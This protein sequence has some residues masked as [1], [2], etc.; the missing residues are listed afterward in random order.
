MGKLKPKKDWKAKFRRR[1]SLEQPPNDV[2][3]YKAEF[4]R[5]VERTLEL[6][7]PNPDPTYSSKRYWTPQVLQDTLTRI[8]HQF[9]IADASVLESNCIRVNYELIDFLQN[10]LTCRAYLTIGWVN[11]AGHDFYK[12]T[13]EEVKGWLERGATSLG[14]E[15]HVWITLDSMEILDITFATT[16]GRQFGSNS[17][18]K[19]VLIDAIDPDTGR[20]HHPFFLGEELLIRMWNRPDGPT[21]VVL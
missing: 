4:E 8:V 16:I 5:A 18:D 9:N 1:E 3:A 19:G 17:H 21:F 14:V 6:G 15:I 7:L 12:I 20:R 13:E 11:V 2:S 10:A